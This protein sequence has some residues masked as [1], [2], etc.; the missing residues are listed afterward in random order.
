MAEINALPPVLERYE[1]KYLIPW[2]YVEPITDY[3]K[4][5]CSMDHFSEIAPENNY[6]YKITSLYFDTPNFEFL[7]QRREGK[8]VRFNMRVRAYGDGDKAPYY[9]EIKNRTGISGVVKK[10]RAT[11]T[12]A[13][14]PAILTDP[15]FRPPDSDVSTEKANKELFLRLALS[16]AI[17]PKILTKY[18]RR[19]FFST[20]DGYVRVT[21]DVNMQYR[22]ELDYNVCS[23]H[24]MINYDN[25]TI[26]ANET[27][28]EGSVVLEL[29]CN[30]GEVPY[31]ILDLVKLFDLKQ[32]S[33]SK[34]VNS[35][36]ICRYDNGNW[37]MPF[38]KHPSFQYL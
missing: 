29:K 18:E 25:E 19:A 33:F 2:K 7:R 27:D 5:Y 38:D 12:E 23:T 28:S 6:F 13:Q 10:Y 14:W 26:Y 36:L 3:L 35:V 1:L 8:A 21:M 22:E 37:F 20:I 34:Y 30:V 32:V 16:Y 17:V 4:A 24:D 9:L 11:A 31:W 15:S